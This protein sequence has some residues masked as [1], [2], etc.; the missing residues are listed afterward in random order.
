MDMKKYSCQREVWWEE[1]AQKDNTEINKDTD[2]VR[3]KDKYRQN[4]ENTKI[5]RGGKGFCVSPIL[6]LH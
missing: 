4:D 5:Q 1:K 2:S 3:E 6:T